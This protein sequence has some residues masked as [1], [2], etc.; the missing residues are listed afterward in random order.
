MPIGKNPL[1]IIR[2]LLITTS[3]IFAVHSDLVSA[4][5]LKKLKVVL[6]YIPNVEMYGPEYA[7]HE[8]FYEE[9]GLDVT[10]IP[11]GQGIDQVQM[12]ANGLA[13]IGISDASHPIIVAA[14][15]GE[16]FKVFG[17]VMQNSPVAMTCRKDSGVTS[18]E[19]LKG[20]NIGVKTAGKPFFEIFLAKNGLS[21]SD[22]HVTPIGGNDIAL[23]ISGRVDCMI[24]TFAF[25]EPFLIEKEGVPVNV[26]PLSRY[27][28]NA[29]ADVYFVKTSFFDN[30]AN[31]DLMVR[32]LRAD[33]KAWATLMHDPKAA[34]KYVID[35]GFVDGLDLDQQTYQAVHQ[36]EYM[37]DPLTAEKGLLWVNQDTFKTNAKYLFDAKLTSK[38]VDTSNIL[39]T[40]ILEKAAPPKF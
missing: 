22:M 28:M 4:E 29:Q 21:S 37:K 20:K 36:V 32:F 25:N 10:L 7:L 39:T 19:Q 3:L 6:G 18:P 1:L 12:V 11:G 31:Q 34:A 15:K 27:G 35:H 2:R 8:H 24:S 13:D 40:T 26:L 16:D 14:D 30:P 38:I 23:I 5:P 33:A 17:A 9:E